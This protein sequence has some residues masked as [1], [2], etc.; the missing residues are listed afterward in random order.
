MK[1]FPYFILAFITIIADQISKWAIVE[2]MVKPR[3][4][5]GDFTP[6]SFFDWYS[7]PTLRWPF[8]SVEVLPFFNLVMVWNQGVS[9]GMFSNDSAFGPLLLSLMSLVIASI[10]I[11]WLFRSRS[12]MQSVAISLVIAGAI[13]NV[14][15]R[16]RFG[17]VIDF[18]DFHAFGYHW[19]A[20]NIA[21][22]S[23]FVGVFLLIVYSFFFE[24][25][26]ET[27]EKSAK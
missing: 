10:F 1:K 27:Q 16:L 21:D 12:A 2:H 5:D 11:V 8:V 22:S 9:F 24:S 7:G 13:G 23:I 6:L 19:P 4:I 15:D 25:R 18:L 26:F 14:I 17:A 20:F 3:I